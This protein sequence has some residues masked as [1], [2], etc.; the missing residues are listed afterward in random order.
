VTVENPREIHKCIQ[1]KLCLLL[2]I[3]DARER[4]S[5]VL[6]EV[7]NL[8]GPFDELDESWQILFQDIASQ[9]SEKSEPP[10][11]KHAIENRRNIFEMW[12][13]LFKREKCRFR[14]KGKRDRAIIARLNDGFSFDD[15]E[16]CLKGYAKDTW[17]HEMPSR[18]E[19]STLLRNAENVET[20]IEQNEKGVCRDTGRN[21]GTN[22][23]RSSAGNK[24]VDYTD[25]DRKRESGFTDMYGN[26]MPSRTAKR[27]EVPGNGHGG[28]E[29]F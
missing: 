5:A 9:S 17:R 20:G 14:P 27:N 19:L 18:N 8:A 3:E 26:P 28:D 7:K 15:I 4:I 21:A 1:D 16:L 12:S 13:K 10:K 2:E 23:G 6:Q 11:D 24:T 22:N 25:E 29:I